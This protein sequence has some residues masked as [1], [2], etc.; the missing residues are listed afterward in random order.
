MNH[1]E[2]LKKY[3][4]SISTIRCTFL[5]RP[6]GQTFAALH[7]F[8]KVFLEYPFKQLIEF[9]TWKGGL[10]MYFLLYC[11]SENA[12][13]TT[14]D[15]LKLPAYID[16][17]KKDILRHV[18]HFD[19]YFK[20]KDIFKEKKNIVNSIQSA[21]RTFLFCDGGDKQLEF[22]T[23][24]PLLKQDD[25]IAVHDWNTEIFLSQIIDTI[26]SYKLEMIY[27]ED[28]L[29]YDNNIRIFKKLI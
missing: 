14:Y 25:I 20:N 4:L 24:A 22:N 5:G 27:E 29:L 17:N 9:G 18:L 2:I 28:C 6:M 13:F 19:K 10:S 7:V 8:E 16:D 3:N 15:T 12:K 21:G 11:L 23:F 26:N 1:D